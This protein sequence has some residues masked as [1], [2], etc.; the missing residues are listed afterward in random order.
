MF[1]QRLS[2]YYWLSNLLVMSI[3]DGGYSRNAS[4][5]GGFFKSL[6]QFVTCT[7]SMNC[8]FQ[9][10]IYLINQTLTIWC[11]IPSGTNSPAA[12]VSTQ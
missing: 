4:Y 10:Y 2:D 6:I 8:K 12:D 5:L 3:P 1:F 11:M 9:Q 7:V